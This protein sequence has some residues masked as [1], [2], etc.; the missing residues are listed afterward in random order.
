MAGIS[1]IEVSAQTN[2]NSPSNYGYVPRIKFRPP[3]TS[4]HAVYK[5]QFPNE[6]CLS[7]YNLLR[8]NFLSQRGVPGIETISFSLHIL[9]LPEQFAVEFVHL[10]SL[11]Y[12]VVW[13]GFDLFPYLRSLA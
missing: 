8:F 9:P 3:L 2:P 10:V 6:D 11:R 1:T 7:T 5:S 12:L 4:C 13:I